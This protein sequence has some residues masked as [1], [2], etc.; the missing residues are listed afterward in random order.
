MDLAINILAEQASVQEGK[1]LLCLVLETLPVGVAVMDQAGDIVLVNDASK[2]IWGGMIEFGHERWSQTKGFWHGS[3]ERIDPKDWASVRALTKGETN[4]NQ[5]IDIETYDGQRKI[6]RNSA[7]PVRNAE[8]LIVGAV[9]VNED[10]TDRVRAEEAL[11]RSEDELR[12]VIDTIP[13]MAW[14]LGPD[15]TVDFLNRRWTEYSGLSLEQF[16]A[17]PTGPMHPED[18]PRA[19]E[20]W[21]VQLEAG[22]AYDDE[23]RLRRADGEYRWFLVRTAPLRNEHG[24]IVK[25]YGVSIDIE[26]RK[27]AEEALRQAS[28]RLRILSRR[29]VQVQEEERQR[30]ARELHDQVGQLLTAAKIDVQSAGAL[31]TDPELNEKLAGAARI[32]ETVLQEVREIS[33]AL[34]PPVLDDLGLAPALRWML[35]DLAGSAGLKAEFSADAN[36]RRADAE[37]ETACYRVAVEAVTNSIRHADARKIMM[38]LRN[39]DHAIQLRVR[40]DG[41][42]FDFAKIERAVERERLGLSGM[43]ERAF[44]VG[45]QFE[46]K[47][48]PGE[49]TEI[50]ARFPI[51]SASE[52]R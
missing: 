52:R 18:V 12:L 17:D 46:I 7:A 11:R 42:G 25:W 9:I 5:L 41:R 19:L 43:R 2:R 28:D 35:S 29:R 47:S 1:Q 32:L 34:R 20:R 31:R 10:V 44:A 16:I 3:G 13:V 36:L 37:S 23:M 30:L 22:E 51:S 33:F 6:M 38:E 24:A 8:G 27:R 26:D 39:I 14:T 15:G 4:L 49:G 48:A 21:R 45:G 40:D 50:I